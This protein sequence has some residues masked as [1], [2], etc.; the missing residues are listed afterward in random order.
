MILFFETY[1]IV[2]TLFFFRFIRRADVVYFHKRSFPPLSF[3]PVVKRIVEILFRLINKNLEIRTLTAEELNEHSCQSNLKATEVVEN[4][5]GDIEKSS[6]YKIILN[7]IK[8][9]NILKFYQ[10]VM[11]DTMSGRVLFYRISEKLR[12]DFK[13]ENFYII[14]ADSDNLLLY[15]NASDRNRLKP[16]IIPCIN[17]ANRIRE[18]GLKI[19]WLSVFLII[20]AV[21]T[22]TWL[23]K[24]SFKP[25]RPRKH[26]I[27][28]P[29]IF[30][31]R[32]EENIIDGVK[33]PH[34]DGYL[35][36]NGISVGDIIHVFDKWRSADENEK[37]I[38][39]VMD[40]RGMHYVDAKD[41][42]VNKNILIFALRIQFEIIKG[43]VLKCFCFKDKTGLVFSSIQVVKQMLKKFVMLENVDFKAELIRN[44]YS[45]LEVV[46]TI[47]CNQKN[48]KTVAIQHGFAAGYAVMNR[49][50]YVHVDKYCVFSDNHV[51]AFSP[52]WDRMHLEKTGSC[53]LDYPIEIAK[54]ESKKS[55]IKDR[56]NQ[57]YGRRKYIVSISL[58]GRN[59]Y[60]MLSRWDMMYQ[61]LE[62][63]IHTDIDSHVFLRFRSTKCL[64][65]G[66][67]QRFCTLPEKD[68]RIIIDLKN[69]TT[70]ELMNVCNVYISSSHSSG[71][72]EA[73]SIGANTFTIDYMD[74]TKFCFDK[75]GKNLVLKTKD[76]ILNIFNNIEN[77]FAGYDCKCDLLKKD[78]DY[79]H[80]GRGR[81]RLQ[82]VM[83]ETVNEINSK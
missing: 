47:L 55:S 34:D 44:D 39:N 80:D 9:S 24:I 49:M 31:F 33:R 81:E 67:I 82:R 42:K 51:K 38:K 5:T 56:I 57:L 20:P 70:Y 65:A 25:I 28:M 13:D 11:A 22:L 4:I 83:L 45:P 23:R 72:I 71:V 69:F 40:K 21:T 66:H 75:Y 73:V 52:F 43:L 60:N 19:F 7:L 12:S 16:H 18:F 62:D 63:F 77:N 64:E 35:Y 76:D 32:E 48:R 36:G 37:R 15:E 3:R 41:Y 61:A 68:K 17:F 14:P 50:C 6:S 27:A 74:T 58:P 29:T 53:W 79:F 2:Q 46:T 59:D 54:S 1:S 78:F 26:A 30:G 8:D 10:S